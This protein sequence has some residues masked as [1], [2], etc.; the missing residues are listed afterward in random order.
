MYIYILIKMFQVS[1]SVNLHADI[2]NLLLFCFENTRCKLQL[3]KKKK[4]NR[5]IVAFGV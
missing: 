4:L 1:L 3:K 2:W 5:D